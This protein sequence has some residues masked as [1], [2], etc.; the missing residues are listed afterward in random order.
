ML[1]I[2][3]KPKWVCRMVQYWPNGTKMKSVAELQ[4]KYNEF[5]GTYFSVPYETIEK[6][7]IDGNVTDID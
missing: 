1:P 5:R 2:G 4:A 6:G 7:S 3:M